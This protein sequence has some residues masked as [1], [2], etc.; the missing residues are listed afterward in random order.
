VSTRRRAAAARRRHPLVDGAARTALDALED[1]LGEL[2][3]EL[4]RQEQA[5]AAG[6]GALASDIRARLS[7]P[8][9]SRLAESGQPVHV[10][11]G[12]AHVNVGQRDPRGPDGAL[13][14]DQAQIRKLRDAKRA[15]VE[16]INDWAHW[17]AKETWSYGRPCDAC[18][19]IRAPKHF[20][21]YWPADQCPHKP[22]EAPQ[23]GRVGAR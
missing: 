11:E 18:G 20:T 16:G 19:R 3:V 7:D 13:H 8:T 15:V 14:G 6:P 5:A 9:P 21:C 4:S 22:A 1:A 10:A 17:L 12:L 2:A 23:K